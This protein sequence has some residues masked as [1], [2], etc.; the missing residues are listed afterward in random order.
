MH[1]FLKGRDISQSIMEV[2]IFHPQAPKIWELVP[3]SIREGKNLSTF[4]NKI[5]V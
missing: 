1:Q 4:K 3:G 5:K 2:K